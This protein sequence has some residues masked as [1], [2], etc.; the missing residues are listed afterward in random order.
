MRQAE[1]IPAARFN[2]RTKKNRYIPAIPLEFIQQ[3]LGAGDALAL[4]LV[5]L[6]EMR[7]CGGN[8]IAIGQGLWAQVGSPGKRV[9][10]RWLRQI[11][12]L[13]SDLCT[14]TSRKGRSHLLMVGPSWPRAREQ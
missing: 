5:A 9:R 2:P 13:P 3:A 14:V 12:A 8:E 10:A 7:I 1:I 6:M 11:A 4:L